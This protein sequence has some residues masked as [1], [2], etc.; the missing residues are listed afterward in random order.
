[1]AT[2]VATAT[3]RWVQSAGPAQ[4]RFTEGVQATTKD[5]TALAAAQ[6]NKLL[7]N[8]QQAVSS[9]RWG[10]NL[11]KVGKAGWQ[12]ATIA[13]AANYGTGINASQAKY[14]QA[15][16]VWMPLINAAAAQV[17]T[18]PKNTIADSAAR[19]TAFMTALH[20]AKL[21]R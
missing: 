17:H 5:P 13:K 15:M 16:G 18:M 19:A 14:E 12:A 6:V 7:A 21:S 11:A 10:R 1:M 8:F 4:T 2:D 20:N 9:G 3:Q